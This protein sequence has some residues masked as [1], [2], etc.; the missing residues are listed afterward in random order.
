[1][2]RLNLDDPRDRLLGRCLLRQAEAFPE[3]SFLLADDERWSYG[4]V[5][6]LANAMARGN[7]MLFSRWM[8]RCTSATR[9][10]ILR[11]SIRRSS[12]ARGGQV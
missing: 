10:C 7:R 6:E 2:N 8:C 5:N 9:I 1:V 4:R 12:D 3:R 11:N